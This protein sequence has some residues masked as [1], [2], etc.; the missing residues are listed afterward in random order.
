L[1]YFTEGIELGKELMEDVYCECGQYLTTYLYVIGKCVQQKSISIRGVP[2]PAK[3]CEKTYS[4][5]KT[6]EDDSEPKVT[7]FFGGEVKS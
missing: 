6:T 4:L 1:G 5:E 7:L 3:G 2:C